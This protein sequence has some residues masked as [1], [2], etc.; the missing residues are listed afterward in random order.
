MTTIAYKDGIIA[1]DSMTTAGDI[2][3]NC[4]LNKKHII[5]GCVFFMSGATCD[6]ERF[7]NVYFNK[8]SN[9]KNLDAAAIIIDN[10]KL[11]LVSVNDDDGLWRQP[12]P[13][14]NPV[15]IGSGQCYALT[16][17]DCGLSAYDAVKMAIKRDCKSGG[18]IRTY[19][20]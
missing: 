13:L 5:D 8:E 17:M 4:N 11:F 15:A 14:D 7:F 2:I 16:A 3:T 10:G 6:Y 20:L 1:Y 9:H 19:K 12:L 18:K